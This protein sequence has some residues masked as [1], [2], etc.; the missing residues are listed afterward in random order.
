MT[1]ESGGENLNNEERDAIIYPRLKAHF[2]R[3]KDII[4]KGDIGYFTGLPTL[5]ECRGKVIVLSNNPEAVGYGTNFWGSNGYSSVDHGAGRP[6]MNI[7]G[8]TFYFE[9]RPIY[10]LRS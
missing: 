10:L 1:R 6:L 7:G 3:Y 5:G 2:E 9:N 4:Y 8:M